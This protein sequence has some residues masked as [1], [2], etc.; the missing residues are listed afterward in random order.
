MIFLI[1]T[2]PGTLAGADAWSSYIE[3]HP[4]ENAAKAPDRIIYL[5]DDSSE[6]RQM[7]QNLK[8]FR[9]YLQ[10]GSYSGT[11]LAEHWTGDRF[12]FDAV[13][14]PV[15]LIHTVKSLTGIFPLDRYLAAHYEHQMLETVPHLSE[16]E[17]DWLNR[18]CLREE[19][20]VQ[21][22]ISENAEKFLKFQRKIYL[23]YDRVD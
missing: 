17:K 5:Q 4:E 2:T 3:R 19:T 1:D 18:H 14:L 23:H 21:D 8:I 10:N 11:S 7:L 12:D 16:T 22:C 20:S 6:H 9:Y 13:I 15:F